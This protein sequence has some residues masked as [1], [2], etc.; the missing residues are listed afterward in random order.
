LEPSYQAVV[1]ALTLMTRSTDAA[2]IRLVLV[3]GDNEY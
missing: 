3:V 1:L 2:E